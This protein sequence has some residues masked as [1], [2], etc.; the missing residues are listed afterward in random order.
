TGN[1]VLFDLESASGHTAQVD[2]APIFGDD[3]AMRPTEML[4]AAL[5]GCTGLNA[6][7]LMK[8]FK[9]PLRSMEVE[10]EG[11]RDEEWPKAFNSIHI[12][13]HRSWAC[14]SVRST[15]WYSITRLAGF[16]LSCSRGISVTI[17]LSG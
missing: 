10:V 1:K 6:V 7:L 9:Q 15:A 2:E 16:A 4:L 13:F 5:G 3:A 11:D 8:K 17:L 14:G 12:P